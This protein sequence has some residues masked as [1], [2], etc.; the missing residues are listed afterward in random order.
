[1]APA[2][3]RHVDSGEWRYDPEA[4]YDPHA[5]Y[6]AEARYDADARYDAEAGRPDGGADTPAA[7]PD[8]W[9]DDPSNAW[10]V[11]PPAPSPQPPPTTR[12]PG[13][14]DPQA[15]FGP[16]VEAPPAPAAPILPGPPPPGRYR[17]LGHDSLGRSGSVPYPSV[18]HSAAANGMPSGPATTVPTGPP[19]G[20]ADSTP[21]AGIQAPAVLSVP[22]PAPAARA[23]S[24]VSSPVRSRH[25]GYAAGTTT[26]EIARIRD[27][28]SQR[29]R[30]RSVDDEIAAGPLLRFTAGWYGVP[31][32]FYLVWLVT[33]DHD[34][35]SLATRGFFASLPWLLGAVVLS[36]MIGLM[37]R[38]VVIG[39]RAFTL[40]F[41]AAIIGAGLTTMA[42]SFVL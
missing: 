16:P 19:G 31:A 22:V 33:L 23:R 41:A 32:V 35:R 4:R 20:A 27:D 28:A 18:T 2:T 34:H 11:I 17:G 13:M 15:W 26:A 38:R 36:L 40:G 42:H 25:P 24:E 37:L 1:V 21:P 30:R 39:W 3:L 12:R 5:Q 10:G 14:Y 9:V 8:L 7:A 6:G 29:W